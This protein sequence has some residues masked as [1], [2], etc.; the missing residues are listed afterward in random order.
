MV[1]AIKTFKVEMNIH[2]AHTH[3]VTVDVVRQAL[4]D[5]KQRKSIMGMVVGKITVTEVIT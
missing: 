4:E 1:D 2:P 3:N 5:S